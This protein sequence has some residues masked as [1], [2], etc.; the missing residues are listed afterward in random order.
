MKPYSSYIALLLLFVVPTWPACAP[1]ACFYQRSS[2]SAIQL[3]HE[4]SVQTHYV[5]T[6]STHSGASAGFWCA[7]LSEEQAKSVPEWDQACEIRKTACIFAAPSENGWQLFPDHPCWKDIRSKWPTERVYVVLSHNPLVVGRLLESDNN[8]TTLSELRELRA[9]TVIGDPRLENP[10]GAT[11]IT[12][13][14]ANAVNTP[15]LPIFEFNSQDPA[16][17]ETLLLAQG[18]VLNIELSGYVRCSTEGG[19]TA[20][21][22]PCAGTVSDVMRLLAAEAPSR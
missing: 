17:S 10:A 8:L 7:M 19:G 9:D 14:Y 13:R 20:E 16:T 11:T 2:M 4:Q 22:T 21:L 12:E 15:H 6:G 18:S 3:V 1:G 5:M